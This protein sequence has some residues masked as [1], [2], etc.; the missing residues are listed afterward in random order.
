MK[1]SMDELNARKKLIRERMHKQRNSLSFE[2]VR[3]KSKKIKDTL[4]SLSYIKES[5]KI[6][7]YV[8]FKNEVSTIDIINELLKMGKEIIVPICDTKDYTLIPSRI[9]SM[10]ELSVSYFGIMEP[11][12]PFIRPV[13]PKDIDVILVPGLA[14]DRN[15]NRLG[16]G[17]G[18]YD[19][20]LR[21]VKDDAIKI[22]LAYDFQILDSI[23]A[24]DW[25]I[26]MDLIITN[27]G[28]V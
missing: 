5:N 20:F 22:A 25:D 13:D 11:K 14:F 24:E 9:L 10:D 27:K 8:S 7:T 26:P 28:I 3:E 19:R 23:P 2:E 18:F 1:N 12:E 6:M 4:F 17:K 21:S 15:R 16:H